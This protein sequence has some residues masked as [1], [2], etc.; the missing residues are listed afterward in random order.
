MRERTQFFR[1]RSSLKVNHSKQ[2]KVLLSS[3]FSQPLL[4]AMV[5][6]CCPQKAGFI[7]VLTN[8]MIESGCNGG[9]GAKDAEEG[10]ALVIT[11]IPSLQAGRLQVIPRGRIKIMIKQ[12]T[13][14]F[15]NIHFVEWLLAIISQSPKGLSWEG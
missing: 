2:T 4:I 1:G 9:G 10:A 3:D 12:T 15:P 13:N 8:N 5:P 11:N 7:K 6:L 14:I